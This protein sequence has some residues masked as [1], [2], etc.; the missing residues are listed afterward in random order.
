MPSLATSVGPID[1]QLS[2]PGGKRRRVFVVSDRYIGPLFSFPV[3]HL[4]AQTCA[5]LFRFLVPLEFQPSQDISLRSRDDPDFVEK[6]VPSGL[7][8]DRSLNDEYF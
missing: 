3:V 4:D 7:E 5:R 1:P 6:V 8:Q 2:D